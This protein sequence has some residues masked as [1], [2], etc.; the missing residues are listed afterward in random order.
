ELKQCKRKL[1]TT[2]I[3]VTDDQA[4]A[5]GLGDRIAVLNQGK[6][7]QVGTPQEIYGNPTDVF[8]ATFIGS[9]PMNLIEDGKTYLGFRPEAFLPKEV[10]PAGDNETF[11]FR[12]SRIEYLGA[13]RL[14]YG[15]L[16]GRSPPAHVISNIPPNL[17]TQRAAGERY[18]FAARKSDI[19]RFARK[20]GGR[21]NGPPR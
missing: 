13:D 11:P 2:T 10:E 17:R 14:V 6:V 7:C 9:P 5:M 20:N 8:V 21:S 16:Q 1:G 18:D 4:E 15:I 19:D 12:I 3:Y